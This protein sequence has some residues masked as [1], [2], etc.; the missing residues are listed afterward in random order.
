MQQVYETLESWMHDF[1]RFSIL[2]LEAI[3]VVLILVAGIRGV[4]EYVR[5][6]PGAQLRM[7]SAMAFALEFKLG[8]EILRTVL[9]RELSEIFI[10]GCIIALRG[11][12]NYLIHRD[13]HE[14]QK[15]QRAEQEEEPQSP[16]FWRAV[17]GPRATPP[18]DP[19]QK[20]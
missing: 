1:T 16:G 13:I 4:V 17:F 7:A 5:H 10:V 3:G 20:P 18:N 15:L 6:R 8:G 2:V 19:E 9:V 14:Q 11:I 12:L